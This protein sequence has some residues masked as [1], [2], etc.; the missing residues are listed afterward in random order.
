ME[1]TMAS[2]NAPTMDRRH[3]PE[4][5]AAVREGQSAMSALDY[6]AMAL[7]IVGGMNWAMVGLFD[8]DVVASVF[9]AGSPATRLVYVLVG[10]AALYAIWTAAKM[11]RG[12]RSA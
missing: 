4:R 10:I 6:L 7:L 8:V 1:D 5:R 9:G 11:G 3:L 12:R 2:M